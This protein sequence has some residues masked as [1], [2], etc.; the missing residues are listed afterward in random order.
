[1]P[2]LQDA[3]WPARSSSEPCGEGMNSTTVHITY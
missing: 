2:Q 3:K 1:M